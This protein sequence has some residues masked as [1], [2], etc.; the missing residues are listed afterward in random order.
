M[1]SDP[2]TGPCSRCGRH[3]DPNKEG[4]VALVGIPAKRVCQEC[5]ERERRQKAAACSVCEHEVENPEGSEGPVCLECY[6]LYLAVEDWPAFE[7]EMRA[8]W[9]TTAPDHKTRVRLMNLRLA[10]EQYEREHLER[11]PMIIR[12]RAG[13]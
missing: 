7:R 5:L 8:R 10:V 1:P 4:E 11:F 3:I 2:W 13:V 6:Q 12:R 9:N